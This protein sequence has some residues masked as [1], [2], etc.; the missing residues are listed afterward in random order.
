[1][2]ASRQS[3]VPELSL[4]TLHSVKQ[5]TGGYAYALGCPRE[6]CVKARKARQREARARR[7]AVFADD[8]SVAHGTFGA[9]EPRLPLRCLLAGNV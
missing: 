8:P 4:V 6:A 3:A 5:G 9:Y 1:M 2:P 7:T